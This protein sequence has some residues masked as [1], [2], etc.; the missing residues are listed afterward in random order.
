LHLLLVALLGIMSDRQCLQD[1]ECF[2]IRHHSVMIKALGLELR[3]P[4]SDS[5]FR[6]S[7]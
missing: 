3:R 4:P 5:S 2:A 6:N 7:F 1:L